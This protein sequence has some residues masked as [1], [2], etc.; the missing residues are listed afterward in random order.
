MPMVFDEKLKMAVAADLA[1]TEA[2]GAPLRWVNRRIS[3]S[4]ASVYVMMAGQSFFSDDLFGARLFFVLF[5]VLGIFFVFLLVKENLGETT[6]LV[7]LAL[8]ASDQFLIGET[9]QI[10]EE[11][12]LL[13]CAAAAMYF[14]FKALKG[15]PAWIIPAAVCLG[16][17]ALFKEIIISVGVSF[18]LFITGSPKYRRYFSRRDIIVACVLI[19]LIVLP[20]A[21]AGLAEGFAH[22]QQEF[23]GFGFSLRVIFLYFGEIP[24]WLRSQAVISLPG[25]ISSEFP[26]V[27]WVTGFLI[28]AAVFYALKKE[29]RRHEL[30]RFCLIL[31]GVVA[32]VATF[33]DPALLD[34][35]WRASLSVYP[36]LIILADLL[37]SF[38]GQRK[39]FKAAT[40]LL[41][42][43]LFVRAFYILPA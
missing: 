1:A 4:L 26:V 27:H 43:Y 34:S 9:A 11:S 3:H 5:G 35:H 31:F 16:A 6:A 19:F 36:G 38:S 24:L 40:A 41:L 39:G 17:G 21:A 25:E 10:R 32:A 23:N 22:Y 28:M 7:A 33:F 2:E 12:P 29:D 18:V 30:I 37:V 14:F 8:L 20:Y 13:L 42:C 15:R